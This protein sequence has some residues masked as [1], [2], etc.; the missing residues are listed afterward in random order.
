MAH[1][2]NAKRL[3]LSI[4]KFVKMSF[5]T[6]KSIKSANQCRTVGWLPSGY[7]ID[8]FDPAWLSIALCL[9]LW[10]IANPNV[11]CQCY[12]WVGGYIKETVK[13]PLQSSIIM[14]VVCFVLV[15]WN[16]VMF[17]IFLYYNDWPETMRIEMAILKYNWKE[18]FNIN[19]K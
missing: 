6:P 8:N 17:D 10:L 12:V 16:F 2:I 11:Q 5:F 4:R 18:C 9:L 19:T 1:P 15:F 7:I 3:Q 13:G 14:L